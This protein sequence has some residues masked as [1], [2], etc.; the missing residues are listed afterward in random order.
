MPLW[1]T[2]L[3]TTMEL[4]SPCYTSIHNGEAQPGEQVTHVALEV[5]PTAE[6]DFPAGHELSAPEAKTQYFPGTASQCEH[7]RQLKSQNIEMKTT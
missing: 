1:Q 5:A 7:K 6:E 4:V 3:P 2:S